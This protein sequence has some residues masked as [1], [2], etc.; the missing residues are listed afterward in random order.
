MAFL[1][2]ENGNRQLY[3]LRANDIQTYLGGEEN[4]NT[5]RKTESYLFSGFGNGISRG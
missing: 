2:A 3:S 1:A 4:Q 5:E